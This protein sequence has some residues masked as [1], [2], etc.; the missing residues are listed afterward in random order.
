M[1][2]LA[3]LPLGMAIP[4]SGS[5]SKAHQAVAWG[6]VTTTAGHNRTA[7]ERRLRSAHGRVSALATQFRDWLLIR[8]DGVRRRREQNTPAG[9]SVVLAYTTATSGFR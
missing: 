1:E 5:P 9:A 8:G 6:L 4:C 7:I 3:E 2:R